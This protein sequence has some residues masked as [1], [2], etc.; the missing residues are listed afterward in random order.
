ME[1]P[2]EVKDVEM[3]ESTPQEGAPENR[4]PTSPQKRER[5][6]SSPESPQKHNARH[7]RQYRCVEDNCSRA[8]IGFAT[9]NDLYRHEKSVHGKHVGKSRSYKCF[10]PGCAKASKLWPRLDNFKQHLIRMHPNEELDALVKKSEKWHADEEEAEAIQGLSNTQESPIISALQNVKRVRSPPRL[11]SQGQLIP[12]TENGVGRQ[13]DLTP[14]TNTPNN[15]APETTSHREV[16]PRPEQ[17]ARVIHNTEEPG[18][19]MQAD[20]TR[21]ISRVAEV[22]EL[23]PEARCLSCQHYNRRC[24]MDQSNPWQCVA[25][26]SPQHCIFRRTVVRE[27]PTSSFSWPEIVGIQNLAR[28]A[29]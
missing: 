1:A 27:G 7:S 14:P 26:P 28:K 22:R 23:A 8:Q 21:E 6:S 29:T 19:V 2:A 3:Y 17:L 11:S 16:G 15:V 18:P 5:S 9:I 13:Y 12:P 24:Y 20:D 25:C 4:A 10:A